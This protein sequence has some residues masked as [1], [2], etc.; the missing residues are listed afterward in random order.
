MEPRWGLMLWWLKKPQETYGKSWLSGLHGACSFFFWGGK[1]TLFFWEINHVLLG[2]IEPSGSLGMSDHAFKGIDSPLSGLHW[3][4]TLSGM[5][6]KEQYGNRVNPKRSG[7]T[8]HFYRWKWAVHGYLHINPSMTG[9]SEWVSPTPSGGSRRVFN[10]GN[11]FISW[12]TLDGSFYLV[13]SMVLDPQQI[14][15]D[16]GVSRTGYGELRGFMRT[17][18]E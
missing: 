8:I 2:S 11:K 18:W 5:I 6:L 13:L 9:T 7:K 17:L 15:K 14:Q 16:A 4:V 10:V 12:E 1:S 3:S